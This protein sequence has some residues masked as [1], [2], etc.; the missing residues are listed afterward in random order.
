MEALPLD[1]GGVL[2]FEGMR[3]RAEA[4]EVES[5]VPVGDRPCLFRMRG[6]FERDFI[7]GMRIGL[8]LGGVVVT[9]VGGVGCV[10]FKICT[11]TAFLLVEL[12][13]V[14]GPEEEGGDSRDDN[15]EELC[16]D[17]RSTLIPNPE[18]AETCL[19]SEDLVPSVNA[20]LFT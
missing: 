6:L 14:A 3:E 12:V 10:L 15:R 2:D 8:L 17:R 1:A 20:G 13:E 19:E 5:E 16:F 4:V 18:V 9:V 11:N 7:L